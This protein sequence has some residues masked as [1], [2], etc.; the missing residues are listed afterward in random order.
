MSSRSPSQLEDCTNFQERRKIRAAIKELQ[1]DAPTDPDPHPHP[2]S[3]AQPQALNGLPNNPSNVVYRATP[4]TPLSNLQAP[5]PSPSSPPPS[6]SSPPP[7]SPEMASASLTSR[8]TLPYRLSSDRLG[9]SSGTASSLGRDSQY[10]AVDSTSPL[11]AVIPDR[12]IRRRDGSLPR[13]MGSRLSAASASALSTD[14]ESRTSAFRRYPS[15]SDSAFTRDAQSRRSFSAREPYSSSVSRDSGTRFSAYSG[16]TP[17]SSL[18]RNEQS[19]LSTSTSSDFY[20][21]ASR[22]DPSDFR[23]TDAGS[24]LSASSSR[25]AYRDSDSRFSSGRDPSLSTETRLGV[26]SGTHPTSS[27]SRGTDPHLSGTTCRDPYKDTESRFSFSKK[28]FSTPL[29]IDTEARTAS[30]ARDL[31]RDSGSMLSATRKDFST[32]PLSIDTEFKPTSASKDHPRFLSASVYDKHDSTHGT[33]SHP[34]PSSPSHRPIS[35]SP[36]SRRHSGGNS[37]S[38]TPSG[39]L[40][41]FSSSLESL[42]EGAH[43]IKH[44]LLSGTDAPQR[45]ASF[46][47]KSHVFLS[48]GD[49]HS[50]PP[51]LP[52]PKRGD[53]GSDSVFLPDKKTSLL[54][55]GSS[56]GRNER[57]LSGVCDVPDGSGV[58]GGAV[59]GRES[60]TV[61]TAPSSLPINQTEDEDELLD[62]LC[63]TEDIKDRLKIRARLRHLKEARQESQRASN[64]GQQAPPSTHS[65]GSRGQS[66]DPTPSTTP[67]AITVTQ[68][69]QPSPPTTSPAAGSTPVDEASDA[70]QQ[71]PAVVKSPTPAADTF[72]SPERAASPSPTEVA[73]VP[74]DNKRASSPVSGVSLSSAPAISGKAPRVKE[75]E[76]TPSPQAGDNRAGPSSDQRP[77]LTRSECERSNTPQGSRDSDAEG[78]F[79]QRSDLSGSSSEKDTALE[80]GKSE[81]TPEVAS[82]EEGRPTSVPGKQK[83]DLTKGEVAPSALLEEE[84][85]LTSEEPA[86]KQKPD[87]TKD[88]N[89]RTADARE[90]ESDLGPKPDDQRPDRTRSPVRRVRR[91]RSAVGESPPVSTDRARQSPSPGSAELG[92]YADIQDIDE[93]RQVLN[94]TPGIDEKRKIRNAMRQ[95]RSNGG[96]ERA[97]SS[98]TRV[99]TSADK[100]TTRAVRSAVTGKDKDS[101]KVASTPL[102]KSQSLKGQQ[103]AASVAYT[104]YERRSSPRHQSAKK[105]KGSSSLLEEK[106][107]AAVSAK[108]KVVP[109]SAESKKGSSSENQLKTG[110]PV[111]SAERDTGVASKQ[112]KPKSSLSS[113]R[114]GKKD[115]ESRL[116]ALVHDKVR[117]AV[118]DKLQTSS[119]PAVKDRVGKQETPK[120]P[121]PTK[122]VAK[123]KDQKAQL[124]ALV[125][126]KVQTAL[127][128]K[129]QTV[130]PGIRQKEGTELQDKNTAPKRSDPESAKKEDKARLSAL[131]QDKVQTAL[132]EKLEPVPVDSTSKDGSPAPRQEKSAAASSP[133]KPEGRI[134][135]AGVT[136]S[137]P[138]KAA[139]SGGGGRSWEH[140]LRGPS[141]IRA[142]IKRPSTPSDTD[143]K[144]SGSRR[145]SVTRT[146]EN[147]GS[148]EKPDRSSPTSSVANGS[149]PRKGGDSAQDSD[150]TSAKEETE[151]SRR[152]PSPFRRER[153]QLRRPSSPLISRSLHKDG[154]PTSAEQVENSTP[155]IKRP[156]SPRLRRL[157]SPFESGSIYDKQSHSPLQSGSNHDKRPP[158]PVLSITGQRRGSSPFLSESG[159]DKQPTSPFQSSSVSSD[160]R[161]PSPV[162]SI[163]RQRR[164]SSPFLSESGIDKQPTSPFQS[165][166]VSSDK[167]PPSPVQ[168]ITRQRR[169]SSPFLSESGIDKQPTSPFQS[170]SVS[171]D[172]RPPSPVQSITRQRRGSSPF[173]SESGINRR[174]PSPSQTGSVS[175]DK[176][177]P[178][179]FQ[180]ITVQRRGSSPFL[181]ESGIDKRPPSPSQTGS[182]SSDK[183]PPSPFQSI[184]AQRR[185]SNPFLSEGAPLG[186][187]PASLAGP[188]KALPASHAEPPARPQ[189][190]RP[191]S[192]FLSDGSQHPANVPQPFLKFQE[193]CFSFENQPKPQHA[194][195]PF[196][197]IIKKEEKRLSELSKTKEREVS[198]RP[199]ETPENEHVKETNGSHKILAEFS[200]RQAQ[201]VVQSE[202]KTR[203]TATAAQ[204]DSPKTAVD[205]TGG[206]P[207]SAA[208]GS[209]VPKTTSVT[210]K[211]SFNWDLLN[212]VKARLH[213]RG[214]SVNSEEE[215]NQ[216]AVH[217]RPSLS[218]SENRD[219]TEKDAKTKSEVRSFGIKSANDTREKPG[220][221]QKPSEPTKTDNDQ[222]KEEPKYREVR[223]KIRNTP[224]SKDLIEKKESPKEAS[225]KDLQPLTEYQKV[226]K[227]L[228]TTV[229]KSRVSS[230]ADKFAAAD[231]SETSSPQLKVFTAVPSRTKSSVSAAGGTSLRRTESFKVS[232]RVDNFEQGSKS[233]LPRRA[234]SFNTHDLQ[235]RPSL[236]KQ[237]AS[238]GQKEAEKSRQTTAPE[239]VKSNE[240]IILRAELTPKETKTTDITATTPPVAKDLSLQAKDFSKED[241]T[242]L[243]TN[244]A[245]EANAANIKSSSQLEAKALPKETAKATCLTEAKG[246]KATPL[247]GQT[248]PKET[249]TAQEEILPKV[250]GV[251]GAKPPPESL[252]QTETITPQTG[253]FRKETDEKTLEPAGTAEVSATT[254]P[255]GSSDRK[256][257]DVTL[258]APH[259]VVSQSSAQPV[260]KQQ[261]AAVGTTPAATQRGKPRVMEQAFTALLDDIET[262]SASEGTPSDLDF[263][264]DSGDEAHAEKSVAPLK[265]SGSKVNVNDNAAILKD[266]NGNS[267][268]D[269]GS[270][271]KD[272]SP[273]DTGSASVPA[274]KRNNSFTKGSNAVSLDPV[275]EEDGSTKNDKIADTPLTITKEDSGIGLGSADLDEVDVAASKASMKPVSDSD[276]LTPTLPSLTDDEGHSSLPS[277][278]LATLHEEDSTPPPP[279]VT[280]PPTLPSST[281]TDPDMT[282]SAFVILKPHIDA[283]VEAQSKRDA[284]SG[285]TVIEDDDGGVTYRKTS[286][287]EQQN[288][289][290]TIKSKVRRTPSDAHEELRDTIVETSFFSPGGAAVK[291]RDVVRSKRKITPRGSNYYQRTTQYIRRI[292]DKEGSD[293]V[294][295]DMC[296]ENDNTS[297][298]DGKTWGDRTVTKVTLDKPSGDLPQSLDELASLPQSLDKPSSDLPQSL[299]ELASLPQLEGGGRRGQGPGPLGVV[300]RM[301]MSKASSGYGSVSGSE[302]EDKEASPLAD[303]Q[304]ARTVAAPEVMTTLKDVTTTE[305][306]V[307]VLECIMSAQ[308]PPDV[309]WYFA[310]TKLD[311]AQEN[312]T[313]HYDVSSGK[314]TLTLHDVAVQDGGTY[315]CVCSNQHG[316]ASTRSSLIVKPSSSEST[317]VP[318]FLIR[319]LNK[320]VND[321]DTLVMECDV[322]GSPEPSILW[323][324]DG[325]DLPDSLSYSTQYDGRVAR[326]QVDNIGVDDEGVFGCV[327]ENSVGKVSMDARVSVQKTNKAPTFT[328]PLQ[329]VTADLGKNVTLTC[330]VTGFP[331]PSVF[332][333]RN[334]L[335]VADTP[336][337]MQSLTRGV[338]RLDI[339]GVREKHG[340]QYECV[341]KNQA[342]DATCFC[343]VNVNMP[344]ATEQQQQ[345]TPPPPV[346]TRRTFKKLSEPHP[347]DV[348][349][350]VLMAGRKVGVQRTQ[351]FSPRSPSVHNS[352]SPST[353]LRAFSVQEGERGLMKGE[354]GASGVSKDTDQ[355]PVEG[356]ALQWTDTKGNVTLDSSVS[357]QDTSSPPSS[358]PTPFQSPRDSSAAASSSSS[359]FGGLTTSSQQQAKD[360]TDCRKFSA[361]LQTQTSVP[362]AASLSMERKFSEPP[363]PSVGRPSQSP[364]SVVSQL[365]AQFTKLDEAKEGGSAGGGGG[366]GGVRRWHSMPLKQERPVVVKRGPSLLAAED[367]GPAT[368]VVSR[369]GDT[370]HTATMSTIAYEQID[371]E[372]E[373]HKMMNA[374]DNFDE[375]KKIRARLK[376]IREKQREEQEARRR[377]REKETEDL[378]RRKFAMA[379]EEK[380]RKMEAYHSQKAT[381]D[382]GSDYA[383]VSQ[384][385]ITDK[386]R[387]A[388]ED[389]QKRLEAYKNIATKEHQRDE[390][391]TSVRTVTTTSKAPDG[392]TSV[393]K[394]TET[395][396]SVKQTPGIGGVQYGG[397]R[398][399]GPEEPGSEIP[400][401]ENAESKGQGNE[402]SEGKEATETTKE[403]PNKDA[404]TSKG[405]EVKESDT[406]IETAKNE[407]IPKS[408]DDPQKNDE[409]AKKDTKGQDQKQ[410]KDTD[411]KQETA[412]G[413]D[414]SSTPKTEGVTKADADKNAASKQAAAG[415]KIAKPQGARGA[416]AAFK[417]MDAANPSAKPTNGLVAVSLAKRAAHTM[418]RNAVVIKEEILRFVKANTQDYENVEVTNFS[419]CWNTGMA[420]CALI[421]HFYPD[422][423]DYSQLD[424]K[425]RRYNFDLAFDT[426]EKL[427]DIAPLLDTDDMVKMKNPDWKCV[428]TYV[429]SIYRHLRDHENN[430]AK[431]PAEAES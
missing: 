88:E 156:P 200:A 48:D 102:P 378:V 186:K 421:H 295:T 218:S 107:K 369:G 172:K 364:R 184:T 20:K 176:R 152:A 390:G 204:Q 177:P 287:N 231:K 135:V 45:V 63:T 334:G 130:S 129:L 19:G 76:S 407:D 244:R 342:G 316:E 127:E 285:V 144:D 388:E 158:S 267:I 242:A 180:S 213:S 195:S 140:T 262:F 373:L 275:L 294:E 396:T 26:S 385:L 147:Q 250:A 66:L 4:Y 179:P 381:C 327:A 254:L 321:G 386:H 279:P 30:I 289:I 345:D 298:S 395:T 227:G 181:S 281:D 90:E 99:T 58:D 353:P 362:G 266:N 46:R 236:E 203:N 61:A 150:Q 427:A 134:F 363:K 228:K 220:D 18:S 292:R 404:V 188:L 237:S 121:S 169:G 64:G 428:F 138:K 149:L 68:P 219:N 65:A 300:G 126:E 104:P 338:A 133:Q 211:E 370:S 247:E 311:T 173:L 110:S 114:G 51:L 229:S 189:I 340:G 115:Q 44:S 336:D 9:T 425:N 183:R 187:Q 343:H 297:V 161:P 201:P 265:D 409:S 216:E 35:P 192:P 351:S 125:Q 331:A 320:T 28:D 148:L 375:R 15:S 232:Q 139:S 163:T 333:R 258:A 357:P 259:V 122:P 328:T 101:A 194:A 196:Q 193:S 178:S 123:Q 332:W 411:K 41:S 414:T 93:L 3:P 314:A 235:R 59:L 307:A 71:P 111:R 416:M 49:Q 215:K 309:T 241:K 326:L 417:Q 73:S 24:R 6:P 80:I 53:R 412:S 398:A 95:L 29:K 74:D 337:F 323:L 368:A 113:D 271:A 282:S 57:T 34:R 98:V 384:K 108:S 263:S 85:G 94:A 413:K 22:R 410:S 238:S 257:K 283:V 87:L 214:D 360:S 33:L 296:V 430:K 348:I 197:P 361:P 240:L 397:G 299:D 319:L 100:D 253:N 81:N 67:P 75:G 217:P 347:T 329:D 274:V 142:V 10:N 146:E 264:S 112:V 354:G 394:K 38:G 352:S 210:R 406:T 408:A 355:R 191:S 251:K 312:F 233:R 256:P 393:T 69:E 403:A 60:V 120:T 230:L 377:Q 175:S 418:R 223:E 284:D 372:E 305:G 143:D 317:V 252:T 62:L 40:G 268:K 301:D 96:L 260:R 341:V 72:K 13:D 50:P 5:P 37:S 224:F 167:R 222:R 105:E 97:S 198:K 359:P 208:K 159:I 313:A 141:P 324:R 8:T 11:F 2:S 36:H 350:A 56:R 420:F 431:V 293:F 212:K 91:W 424:P 83:T 429:Q 136:V 349:T 205:S 118:E 339:R 255:S 402:V 335:M 221:Q 376:E 23:S 239:E 371:D 47:R 382:R 330:T 155:Q 132:N 164:G 1:R 157:S 84:G 270:V 422:A 117:S 119:S 392:S 170:S 280:Q 426:A 304:P 423:F 162:Q 137:E 415:Q 160:K 243:V 234:E 391:K 249:K 12:V 277:Q 55:A 318:M 31:H 272:S 401:A 405:P 400:S 92:E 151:S 306:Q 89:T 27:V 199:D 128:E 185:G 261:P 42:A 166:S 43:I 82:E 278:P 78:G 325:L 365:R 16:R 344:P 171:S 131:V 154:E 308:P 103:D 116:S 54:S 190:R 86:G 226:E 153:S 206:Q 288:R 310:D 374:T 182:V 246:S 225:S 174:P 25:D 209:E 248:F 356:Y 315:T 366:G 52:S 70:A 389:K 358:G 39:G 367:R 168:S 7:S 202:L 387:Q 419:S 207:E 124:S 17:S 273:E 21:P 399:A 14:P 245:N 302:E 383:N 380:K 79:R 286:L 322:I 77:D 32:P 291:E 145:N 106:V 290:V 109:K 303:V 276:V 379:E 269:I 346:T 165:S